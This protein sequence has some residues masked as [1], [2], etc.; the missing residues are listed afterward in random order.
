MSR[1]R[2][3]AGPL[4][5]IDLNASLDELEALAAGGTAYLAAL[6]AALPSAAAGVLYGGSGAA[7]TAALVTPTAG[8]GYSGGNLFVSFGAVA[9]AM[10]GT[11]SAGSAATASRSD[12]VHPP[13]TSRLAAASNLSDLA[14]AA[15]ARTNLGLGGAATLS[16]GSAAGTVASGDD[17]RITGAAQKASNLSDLASA[18]AARTNLG[19]GGAATLNVGSSAGTV[20]SGNDVRFTTSFTSVAV[21][22]VPASGGGTTNYLRADGAWAA[23]PGTGG[24]GLGSATPLMN[25]TAAV[26][27]SASAS[28]EDHVHPTDTTRAP[29]D[30]PSFTTKIT[31]PGYAAASLPAVAAASLVYDTTGSKLR[32]STSSSWETVVTRSDA[33]S[34]APPMNGTGSAGSTSL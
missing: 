34:S 6:Q 19:L 15:A 1:T 21:G 9:P 5:H 26:G 24:T 4:S 32:V 7:G 18:A 8:L 33:Y 10:N 29:L 16:V 20:A 12:H 30:A 11:A 17:G 13:D 31:L 23:P 28:H 22:V 27:T 25:G 2:F 3:A 14:S